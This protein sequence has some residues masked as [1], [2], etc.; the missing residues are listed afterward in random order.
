MTVKNTK[1][2]HTEQIKM[3]IY[4]SS[5]VG[6]TTLAGTITDGITVIISA[7]SGLLC[8]SDKEIDVLEVK[9]FEQVRDAYLF[10]LKESNY[11]NVFIDSLTEISDMLVSHLEKQPEFKDPKNTLKM[12][13][14]YNKKMTE[15]IKS[16]RDLNKNVIFTALPD[17]VQDSGVITKKPLIKGTATQK[18]LCSYFDE[19][20]YLAIDP[21]T[22]ERQIQTQPTNNIEA[23]D[24]S[25]KLLDY[26]EP[27]LQ[28]II[29]KIKGK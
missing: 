24:R 8:L 1:G 20:F 5:G 7:E 25:G 17:D 9:T 10:V 19:V 23:K 29:N 2:L 28:N 18:L 16:F 14:E 3:L 27:N 15:L 4:A 26:E 11:D 21:I 6:K 13:G 12:W 22:K